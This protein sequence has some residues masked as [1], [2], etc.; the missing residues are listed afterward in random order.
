[1]IAPMTAIVPNM[2]SAALVQTS[3]GEGPGDGA[4][5]TGDRAHTSLSFDAVMARTCISLPES[6]PRPP[7]N[8][9][10]DL[11][12]QATPTPPSAR[13]DG[14]QSDN[15]SISDGSPEV[16][17]SKDKDDPALTDA[18]NND[19]L[20]AC[21][22]DASA[23][24]GPNSFPAFDGPVLRPAGTVPST[25]P[26]AGSLTRAAPTAFDKSMPGAAGIR[27]HEGRP[28]AA[29]QPGNGPDPLT[30]TIAVL[31]TVSPAAR[32]SSFEPLSTLQLPAF[33]H[34][35]KGPVDIPQS[36]VPDQPPISVS[37]IS[38][39]GA[40][41]SSSFAPP[42]MAAIAPPRADTPV[43]LAPGDW[44]AQLAE[45]IVTEIREPGNLA[46]R[47]TPHHLGML[48]ISLIDNGQGL[49]IEMRTSN[50]DT[51]SLL[52]REEQR[53][54]DEMRARGVAVTDC[55]IRNGGGDS[56]ARH[57]NGAN[58]KAF[59]PFNDIGRLAAEKGDRLQAGET[60]WRGRFA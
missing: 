24:S 6:P 2:S 51:V 43:A 53:L 29:I 39:L 4:V 56:E 33:A 19:T 49:V 44:A 25:V 60:S 32:A 15:S 31:E 21:K 57:Q 58:S 27:F 17:R 37:A 20:P 23:W 47:L 13:S 5:E 48:E 12:D 52:A 9:S 16:G 35:A 34:T 8:L 38:E 36:S 26:V 1:M 45:K 18:G 54:L 59:Q 22:A 30:G 42:V 3:K 7:E 46:L 11:A 28:A 14:D 10:M 41:T 55:S 40:M 50:A